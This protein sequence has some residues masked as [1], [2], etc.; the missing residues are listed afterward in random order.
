MLVGISF[1]YTLRR[2][3]LVTLAARAR[4]ADDPRRTRIHVRRRAD[5][6]CH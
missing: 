3:Q 6:L 5:E 2:E 4:A 1:F